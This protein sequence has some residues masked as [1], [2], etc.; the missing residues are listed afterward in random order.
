MILEVNVPKQLPKDFK[1]DLRAA[2]LYFLIEQGKVKYEEKIS[3]ANKEYKNYKSIV[4]EKNCIERCEFTK[5]CRRYGRAVGKLGTVDPVTGF[6]IDQFEMAYI[7]KI[8]GKL[9]EVKEEI[10]KRQ[11]IDS[12]EVCKLHV[13]LKIEE[14]KL[15]LQI[16]AIREYCKEYRNSKK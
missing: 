13:N 5:Y 12:I 16:E 7:A 3:L 10:R 14:E 4:G 2:E 9:K 15:R 1:K 8:E 6:G 11:I